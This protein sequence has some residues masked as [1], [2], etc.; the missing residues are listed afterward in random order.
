MRPNVKPKAK[1][2]MKHTTWERSRKHA[3]GRP[4]HHDQAASAA[5]AVSDEDEVQNDDP[6]A[7]PPHHRSICGH[8]AG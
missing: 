4:V 5:L 6:I 8:N 3:H 7:P 1:A 2:N